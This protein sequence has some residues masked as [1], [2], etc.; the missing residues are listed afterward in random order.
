MWRRG[1]LSERLTSAQHDR[2]DRKHRRRHELRAPIEVR[3]AER[4]SMWSHAKAWFSALRVRGAVITVTPRCQ[5]TVK[6]T[7]ANPNPAPCS[8]KL[9]RVVAG[10]ECV[11]CGRRVAV[12]A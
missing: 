2:R 1:T 3:H 12:A 9:R 7:E 10:Y 11:L 5:F 8:G 4:A 6:P